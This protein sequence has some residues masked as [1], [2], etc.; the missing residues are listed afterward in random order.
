MQNL[1]S[2]Q[3]GKNKYIEN[4]S[5]L[6]YTPYETVFIWSACFWGKISIKIKNKYGYVYEVNT[7]ARI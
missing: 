4:Q 2:I 6:C 3:T 5:I 1:K 7:Y